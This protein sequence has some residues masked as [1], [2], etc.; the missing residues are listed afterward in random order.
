MPDRDVASDH[1]GKFVRQMNDGVVLDVRAAADEDAIDVAP[2]DGVIPHARM[3]AE[4]HI[5]QHHCAASNIDLLAENRFPAQKF[6][7]LSNHVD[8]ALVKT[9]LPGHAKIKPTAQFLLEI[10]S[11]AARLRLAG[12][13]NS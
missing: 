5:A 6:F 8:H 10:F 11:A 1:T 3:I 9:K 12:K 7:K 4:S 13:R 2:H